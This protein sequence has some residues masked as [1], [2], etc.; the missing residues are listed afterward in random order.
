[1]VDDLQAARLSAVTGRALSRRRF[2]HRGAA[3]LACGALR[4]RAVESGWSAGVGRA[5][6]T[7]TGPVWMAGY[8]A[9]TREGDA[10]LQDLWVKAI[11]LRDPQGA[12][13]VLV[14]ADSCG[15]ARPVADAIAT[16][17]ARRHGLKRAALL[18]N[19]S[20]TH[21]APFTAGLVDAMREFSAGEWEPIV[22]YTRFFEQRTNDAIATAFGDFEPVTLS[23]GRGTATFAVN[24]RNNVEADV[25]RLRAEN[26]LAGPVDH[27]LPVL[28]VRSRRGLKAVVCS[29]ACHNTTLSGYEWSGDY[30]GYAQ[31]EIERR[32]PGATALFAAGCGGDINPLPRRTVEL[33][34]RYG[35][36]LADGVDAALGN[37]TT[38]RGKLNTAFE[39]VDLR[40]ARIPGRAE[41]ERLA[42]D[43][44]REQR[45]ERLRARHLLRVLE[46]EGALPASYP[47]PV[48]AWR[49]GELTWIALGGE[50]V[51]DYALQ[52]KRSLPGPAWV[53]GYSNEI[54]AYIPTERI[55]REGGY[56]GGEAMAVFGRPAPWAAGLE[57]KICDAARRLARI[58]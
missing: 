55:L 32:H 49:V 15:I 39:R 56:E 26:K 9:R 4:L 51:V 19:L 16:E 18:I 50:P 1:M 34:Q 5:K 7:P 8:G 52:L 24:R 53:L 2:L 54:M 38:V 44:S 23:H 25:P 13:A 28:A 37:G 46:R 31:E 42:H 40:Y 3:A 45:Y 47:Y 57:G 20:H 17:A 11:A 6:I 30:A 35:R 36:E 58:A 48:Q 29:Y 10:T 22:G 43:E 21:C 14:T 33:A 12:I 27:E 41:L